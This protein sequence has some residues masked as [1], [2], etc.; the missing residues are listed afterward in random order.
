MSLRLTLPL[1]VAIAV[2]CPAR[3]DGPG[4]LFDRE[5]LVAWCI[6]PFDAAER[7]SHERASMIRRLGLRRVAY[8]WRAEHVSTFEDEIRAYRQHG[9]EFFAFWSWHP[10]FAA[11]VRK[12]EIRPQFWLTNPSPEGDS[13]DARIET[14]ARQLLPTVQQAA[15]LECRVGLYNHGGWGGEPEN[16]VAVARHLRTVCQADN[17]G[18]VYNLHHGHDHIERFESA[19]DVMKPYLLCLNL[20]GMVD[21]SEVDGLQNKIVPVGEGQHEQ[22]L[23]RLIGESGYK[24]PIGI[25][26]HRIDVDAETA[27]LENLEG[28]E[29][30]LR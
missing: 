4:D 15:E 26:D 30:L 29:R 5:N 23:I 7:N 2:V 21:P 22:R 10:E 6:V 16:L 12:Y 9:I 17:V 1:L 24:G 28:L 20:N 27:L 3:G 25:L 18:I 8:D 14:A 11:L 13:Q 19:L